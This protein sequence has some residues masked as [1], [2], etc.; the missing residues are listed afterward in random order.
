[1]LSRSPFKSKGLIRNGY[2]VE[3]IALYCILVFASLRVFASEPKGIRIGMDG[4][5]GVATIKVS[6]STRLE[7]PGTFS[8]LAE[9]T[10]TSLQILGVEHF[11]TL[12]EDNGPSSGVGYSGLYYKYFMFSPR[13]QILPENQIIDSDAFYSIRLNPYLGL[14]M[15]IGQASLRSLNKSQSDGRALSVGTLAG[16]KLGVEMPIYKNYAMFS[17]ASAVIS[18]IG[19]GSIFFYR[20]TL[21]L[22]YSF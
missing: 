14:S 21:G 7:G 8:I 17:E 20:G 1:M 22:L 15:G 4:G 3:L 11:R 6:G 13:S 18:I 12:V 16:G 19:T 5:L 9:Y 2:Q 10:L